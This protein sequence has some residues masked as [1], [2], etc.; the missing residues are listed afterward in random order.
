M[1]K[2]YLAALSLTATLLCGCG[3]MYNTEY[4]YTPPKSDVGIMCVSN[5]ASNKSNCRRE[6]D[7]RN[8]NC[9]YRAERDYHWCLSHQGKDDKDKCFKSY[10]SPNYSNCDS[11]YN[12]CFQGCGGVVTPHQVCVAFCN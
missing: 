12:T 2:I 5:C 11:E 4:I 7:L 9:E 3:P 1:K 8:E 10:C 6:E